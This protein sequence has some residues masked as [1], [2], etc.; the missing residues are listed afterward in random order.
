MKENQIKCELNADK[1]LD[2][3]LY[4]I[5][6]EEN[7][8]NNQILMNSF[9]FDCKCALFLVDMNNYDSLFIVKDII[10]NID[11]EKYPYLQKIIIENKSDISPETPD[12]ELRK[13]L[14]D[15]K[16]IDY[17][18]ISVKTGYN[19]DNLLNKIYDEVNSPEN[20]VFPIDK[21]SKDNLRV[22]TKNNISGVINLIL[23]GESCVG[24]TNFMT[25][26]TRNMFNQIFV[27]TVTGVNKEYKMLKINDK[28]YNLTFWDTVGQERFKSIPRKY[29]Q[30]ADGVL[31]LFDINDKTTF[32][33]I[34][35]WMD[36]VNEDTY[37]T[38]EGDTEEITGKRI[39]VYI[40]GNKIDLLENEKEEISKKEKDDLAKKLGAKYYEVSCKWNLNIEEVTSRIIFDT[41]KT[42]RPRSKTIVLTKQ[43]V[44]MKTPLEK[45]GGCCSSSKKGE[46][47][48]NKRSNK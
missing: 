19:I 47:N 39:P 37:K 41:I 12:D 1:F 24:K 11:D 10:L 15:N 29:F 20:N 18:K 48:K 9:F 30:N 43:S 17:I 44:N 8:I 23:L 45:K 46:K 25:R 32:E 28:Y 27:S 34:S 26:Y 35:N 36:K 16:D 2:I 4:E 42:L 22:Y 6:I 3:N 7:I 21:I 31:L 14:N 38:T 13:F 33:E 40:I 5:R